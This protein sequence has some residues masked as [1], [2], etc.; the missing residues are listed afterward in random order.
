MSDPAPAHAPDEVLLGFTRALRAA[1]VPVTQDRAQE[2]LRAT[3]VLGLG[4]Q[5]ATWTAGRATLC[6]CREDLVRHDRV[7]EAWFAPEAETLTRRPRPVTVES[8]V[9]PLVSR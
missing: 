4:D 3:A 9:A 2:F 5:R 1:G 8:A 6:G 7:F